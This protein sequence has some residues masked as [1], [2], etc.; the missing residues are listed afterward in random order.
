MF[1]KKDIETILKI[2]G[3]NPTAPDEEIQSVLLN[4]R[5][6]NDEVDTAIMVLRE[7]TSTH[8]TRVEG[9][10][11]IFRSDE[12]LKPAEI[13]SLL[14]INIEVDEV[15]IQRRCRREPSNYQKVVMT[16][17]TLALGIGGFFLAMYFY[18]VGLFH[19]SASAFGSL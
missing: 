2:N 19:P 17:F 15:A 7:N 18:K 11:K 8:Q 3:V 12:T 14:G 4:A 5:Y 13:S 1:Q 9:M 16:I 6:N 10:H